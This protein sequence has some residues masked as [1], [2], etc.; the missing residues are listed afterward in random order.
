MKESDKDRL[1]VKEKTPGT[2]SVTVV[3][4][5]TVVKASVFI[6]LKSFCGWE[7]G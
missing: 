2:W 4:M 3:F 7:V 5:R 6:I 1:R